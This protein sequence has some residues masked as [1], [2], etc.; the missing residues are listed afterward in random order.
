MITLVP[1]GSDAKSCSYFASQLAAKTPRRGSRSGQGANTRTQ[2]TPR[3]FTAA[4][5]GALGSR[6]PTPATAARATGAPTVAAI[7]PTR[8]ASRAFRA[9]PRLLHALPRLGRRRDEYGP[10]TLRG[11]GR[12]QEQK[13]LPIPGIIVR[14]GDVL[15]RTIAA[16]DG[17][18][19][20]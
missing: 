18:G 4:I 8:P 2:A 7:R 11:Q 9:P 13:C 17:G 6:T 10:W 15:E 5:W 14:R 3:G 12:A 1:A 20:M 19:S 16:L